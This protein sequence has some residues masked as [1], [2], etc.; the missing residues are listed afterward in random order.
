VKNGVISKER[1][2]ES[3]YRILKLKHKYKL[4]DNII[5]S[6]DVEKINKKIDNL[7][8]YFK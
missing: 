2:D 7:L 3:V 1:L 4:T 5:E 6:I 8:T